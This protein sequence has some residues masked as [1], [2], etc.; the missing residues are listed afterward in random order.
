MREIKFRAWFK[1]EKRWLGEHDFKISPNGQ[2]A[3]YGLY[4][5]PINDIA[6]MQFTGLKDKNEKEI[7]EGDVC[8]YKW[9]S[10]V[11]GDVTSEGIAEVFY[12]GA[13]FAVDHLL[14]NHISHTEIEIIGNIYS[15]PNLLN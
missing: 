1:K 2:T 8:K 10:E 15:N 13:S 14:L 9:R 6:I 11:G 12:F 7:W 4:C 3:T 5:H